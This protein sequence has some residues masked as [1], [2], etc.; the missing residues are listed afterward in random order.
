MAK[1]Q[2]YNHERIPRRDP[3][4]G[5]EI[6]QLTSF[7]VP[8][9]AL[10]YMSTC[11][12]PDSRTLVF[13]SQREARRDSPFDLFRVDADGSRL[14]QLTD[15]DN[16]SGVLVS[17]DGS[18]VLYMRGC[19][20]WATELET[21]RDE[22]LC[23]EKRIERPVSGASIS[24][25]GQFYFVCVQLRPLG[26]ARGEPPGRAIA[27]FRTDGSG[28]DLLP[29]EKG[30]YIHAC[31][32]G[33][34]GLLCGLLSD[35]AHDFWLL[36]YDAGNDRFFTRNVFAHSSW[37]GGTGKVQGCALFPICAIL[38][39]SCGQRDP[40]PL[41]EGPYFW[42]SS[43]T[44]DGE[45]IVADTN[46]PDEGLQLVNVR[47]RR[48]RTLCYPLASEG[49]PQ[50][51]HPHPTFSPDGKLALFGSDRTG[52]AQLYLAKV[53]DEMREDLSRLA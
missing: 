49:H 2:T 26:S 24:H 31:D 37:L 28:V 50:W 7:P 33:G 30:Y 6:L 8:S 19:Q 3:T 13:S 32:P 17:R 35:S 51:T 27:R 34:S 45:W 21:C 29:N 12:T 39:A 53:P 46:W 4:T 41:V 15:A 22:M 43:A 5:V 10:S 47:T 42:H 52:I 9:M 48:F 36:D 40:E 16:I 44:L 14:T 20:L 18:R 25:D 38:V 23:E 1:G 11:F